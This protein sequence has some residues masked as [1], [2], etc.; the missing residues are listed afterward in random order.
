MM[1][2][3]RTVLLVLLLTSPGYALDDGLAKTPY[4]GWNTWYAFGGKFDEKKLREVADS[5][6]SSGLREAGYTYLCLDDCWSS[7]SRDADGKLVADPAK[8]PS[9]MKAFSDY[10]HERGLKLGIYGDRGTQT[11]AGYPGSFG[12]EAVDAKTFADWGVDLVKYDNCHGVGPASDAYIAF[13]NALQATKRPMIYNIC[14]WGEDRVW[15]WGANVGHSWRTFDD[16]G[17]GG[18]GWTRV[19]EYGADVN[20]ELWKFAGPAHWNDAEYL[21]IGVTNLTREESRA[22]FSLWCL[23][24]SPLILAVDVPKMPSWVRDIVTEKEV[25]AVNQD[26]KGIQGRKIRLVNPVTA[27]VND[28]VKM[29]V[30]RG[31]YEIWGGKPLADGSQAVVL[32][33]R[34]TQSASI[35]LTAEDLGY[36]PQVRFH[37]RDLWKHQDLGLF[38]NS[39]STSVAPHG[40]VMYRVR[41]EHDTRSNS[42]KKT[43]GTVENKETA[44]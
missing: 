37:V 22:K 25:I 44:K 14:N 29:T 16:I 5:M 3:G 7:K 19:F 20:A 41:L 15:E 18:G 6:I 2:M 9:G 8:F 23:M 26:A 39:M 10:C 43:V 32:F 36:S 30:H 1:K 31:D 35:S 24:A 13:R 21:L 28:H 38:T 40:V 11:C 34:T 12:F 17:K 27:Q 33:N 4:M 42:G